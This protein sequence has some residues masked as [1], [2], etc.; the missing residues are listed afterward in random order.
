MAG[1]RRD[2]GELQ[3]NFGA[4]QKRSSQGGRRTAAE[5]GVPCM[6]DHGVLRRWKEKIDLEH[7]NIT[8]AHHMR[9]RGGARPS[10]PNPETSVPI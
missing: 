8:A 1:S 6:C 10:N 3:A 5:L 4:W 9:V 2:Y 7:T